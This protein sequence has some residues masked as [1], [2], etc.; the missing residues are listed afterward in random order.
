MPFICLYF[1]NE[2]HI[3]FETVLK[4]LVRAAK[5]FDNILLHSQS[6]EQVED[7]NARLEIMKV[8]Q[9]YSTSGIVLIILLLYC[10]TKTSYGG[11]F[12]TAFNPLTLSL[13]RSN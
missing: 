11:L 13:S 12:I 6:L 1:A 3:S 5:Y 7:L 4:V 2:N 10:S 9:C 8:L